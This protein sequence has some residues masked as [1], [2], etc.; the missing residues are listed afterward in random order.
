M[1]GGGHLGQNNLDT[2]SW[3]PWM[4]AEEPFPNPSREPQ[5]FIAVLNRT[6]RCPPLGMVGSDTFGK[7]VAEG[8]IFL[9]AL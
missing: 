9:L 2:D 8:L 3:W 6:L 1:M 7:V 4:G 5:A